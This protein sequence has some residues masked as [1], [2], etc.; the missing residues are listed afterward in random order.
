M[1]TVD[2]IAK[3]G[4]INWLFQSHELIY[5]LKMFFHMCTSIYFSV[6]YMRIK[7]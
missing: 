3:S 5:L 1:E 7:V 4:L 2:Y 6:F